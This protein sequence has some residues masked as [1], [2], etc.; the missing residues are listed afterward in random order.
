MCETYSHTP[1]Q[2]TISKIVPVLYVSK[3]GLTSGKFTL[4]CAL[5]LVIP[6]SFSL[7]VSTSLTKLWMDLDTCSYIYDRTYTHVNAYVPRR[8]CG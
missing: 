6:R 4:I 2:F 7:S 8:E 3:A 1:N 5:D